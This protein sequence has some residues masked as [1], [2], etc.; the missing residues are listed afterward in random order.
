MK[1]IEFSPLKNSLAKVCGYIH[2]PITEMETCRTSFP[3][4]VICPGG[5]YI[6]VSERE[7]DPVAL[8]Y[9]A[10][11]YNVFILDYSVCDNAKNFQPLCELSALFCTIRQNADEWHT[12]PARIAVCGFSAGG[13]L[14]ASL[15]T[16]WNHENLKAVFDTQN[17][18]NKPSAMILCYPVITADKRYAHVGSIESVSGKSINDHEAEFFSLENR[19]GDETVPAFVFHTADDAT[20]KVENSLLFISALQENGIPYE[21][22]ILPSGRHGLS[23]CTEETGQRDDYNARWMDMSIMW[24]NKLFDYHI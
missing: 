8:R 4:V 23:V 18:M 2:T 17:G 11:G 6:C 3:A 1:K 16:L 21:C 9:F 7:A 13:H 12:D 20:V 19:V 22:H 5:G 14:A 24:L 15:G 10:A